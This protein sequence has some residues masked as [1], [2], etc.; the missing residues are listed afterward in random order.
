MWEFRLSCIDDLKEMNERLGLDVDAVEDVS[1]L[2]EPVHAGR[3]VI[4]NSLAVHPM[5]GCDGTAGGEPTG[6]TVRRYERFATGGAR[7]FHPYLARAAAGA[8]VDGFFIEVHPDPSRALSDATT[9][10]SLEE[11][12]ELL[13]QLERVSAA[14]RGMAE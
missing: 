1:I 3:L 8:G 13:G 14:V 4:P 10:L 7:E 2:A 9:Q 12:D 11:L 5:E 6:L